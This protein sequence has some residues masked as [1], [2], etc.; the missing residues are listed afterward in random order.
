MK[1]FSLLVIPALLF[2]H[3]ASLSPDLPE[4]P[5]RS[6]KM[7]EVTCDKPFVSVGP[8]LTDL[9][10]NEY[11]R[12]DGTQTGY[13]GGLYPAGSNIRPPA[14]EAAG[15]AMASRIQP[16]D[17]GGNPDPQ[18]GR[19]VMISVGMSNT[20][21][22]FTVFIDL[23]AREQALNPQLD[24]INGAQGGMVSYDWVN[25]DA[26][27]WDVVDQRLAD[28][29]LTPAQVQ[30][31][32]VKQTRPGQGDFPDQA[33]II[34]GDLEAITR[35][36]LIRYPNIE[37]A[38]YSSRTRSYRIWT[39][40]SPEPAAFENGFSVK[41]MIEKQISGDPSLNFDSGTG[42]PV[43]APYLSWGPYIWAD[44]INPRSDGFA[45]LPEDMQSDCTHPSAAG[46][47]K[48]AS[49][50]VRFFST[51][52]TSSCWF[53]H[54]AGPI[55]CYRLYLPGIRFSASQ[56]G[57]RIDSAAGGGANSWIGPQSGLEILFLVLASGVGAAYLLRRRS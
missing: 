18:N 22:E 49:E 39:G 51:D 41:W 11:V 13:I 24:I 14:H 8:A 16:L 42:D 40:L 55:M 47:L 36:L 3:L 17:G 12:I 54:E 30:V 26:A 10:P 21:Q 15:L 29:G 48:I 53:L 56:S 5:G 38:Y 31:A 52:T 9:G 23:A 50:L 45:W 2:G 33:Q 44:G 20:S 6:V 28:V 27:T 4:T 46:S 57:E 43:V 37:I 19:I 32:W 7:Q 1:R 35:N 34:Q 25:P